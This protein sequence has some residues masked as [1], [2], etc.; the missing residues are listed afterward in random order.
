MAAI[1]NPEGAALGAEGDCEPDLARAT[2]RGGAL[3]Q[4]GPSLVHKGDDPVRGAL[5][6]AGTHVMEAK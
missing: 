1:A 5:Q 3:G 4:H 2:G 6:A